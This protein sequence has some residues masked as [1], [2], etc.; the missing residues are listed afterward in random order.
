MLIIKDQLPGKELI[1]DRAVKWRL[2]GIIKGQRYFTERLAGVIYA[3]I[4]KLL[5]QIHAI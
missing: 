4:P 1:K 3:I 2:L 5:L